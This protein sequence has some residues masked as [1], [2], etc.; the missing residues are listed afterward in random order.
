MSSIETFNKLRKIFGDNPFF[1][2]DCMDF[3]PE[4]LEGWVKSYEVESFIPKIQHPGRTMALHLTSPNKDGA[5]NWNTESIDY[6]TKF[7]VVSEIDLCYTMQP[8]TMLGCNSK[9]NTVDMVPIPDNF[10]VTFRVH[11][12]VGNDLIL[13]KYLQY[14]EF[15]NLCHYTPK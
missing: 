1:P 5:A 12:R 11:K 13:V 7:K 9:T 14:T 10:P 15:G 6:I 2:I 8:I 3:D 4:K